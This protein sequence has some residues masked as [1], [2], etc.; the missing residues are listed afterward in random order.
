[1]SVEW[2]PELTLN[3]DQLDRQHVEIFRRLRDSVA[4]LDGTRADVERAVALLADVIVDHVVAEER[5]MEATLYPER[6]R[7]RAAH[8]LFVADVARMREELRDTGA[9]P[10][11]AEWLR[12][13][14][15]EWLHFHIRVNDAPLGAYLARRR[16]QGAE[17]RAR[18]NDVRRPS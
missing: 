14:I 10:V 7:H 4:A 12:V 13:R 6:A 1:M 2:T 18:P 17:P 8:E 5:L 11:V 16:S 9:T 15:P 3:H